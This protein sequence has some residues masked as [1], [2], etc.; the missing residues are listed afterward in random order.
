MIFYCVYN[1]SSVLQERCQSITHGRENI[2]Q[3]C[4]AVHVSDRNAKD[5]FTATDTDLKMSG[6]TWENAA[7]PK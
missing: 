4:F 2:P 7:H 3:E 5:Q 6:G 1:C